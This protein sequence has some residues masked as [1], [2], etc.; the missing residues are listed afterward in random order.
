MRQELNVTAVERVRTMLE[1]ERVEEER[2][3]IL[4]GEGMLGFWGRTWGANCPG[5][6]VPDSSTRRLDLR[7]PSAG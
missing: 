7:N 6:G 1:Q 5:A 4:T 3:R 2:V